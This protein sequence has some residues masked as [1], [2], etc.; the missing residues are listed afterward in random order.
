MN[1]REIYSEK[2][3]SKINKS[4]RK[5]PKI[6][7]EVYPPTN[8]DISKLFEELRILKKL[9]PALIS[10]TYGAEGVSKKF[11]KEILKSILDLELNLIPHFT[12]IC[13][14][15]SNIEKYIIDIENLGIENVLVLRGDMQNNISPCTLDFEHSNELVEYIHSRTDLS[16]GVAGYPEG[17][18]ESKSIAD[19]M[20]NLK[21]KV[22][23]G[24][25]AIFSQIFF[26]NNSFYKFQEISQKIGINIPIIAGIMPVRSLQQLEKISSLCKVKIPD[27]LKKQ[28]EKFPNDS[29]KIGIEYA[30][31]QC[32]DLIDNEVKGL[33][34]FTLNHSDMVSEI[35]ENI[36]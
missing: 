15:Q 18:F 23:A 17:H 34:F 11:S 12:C 2:D 19:D 22:E 31:S 27:K 20:L 6:S 5:V 14:N 30:T 25:S 3:L 26:D 9:N 16:I 29:K 35:I 10:L 7:F 8:N 28:L 36:L 4:P 32:Q 1:L 13:N 21:R 33:H 24:A